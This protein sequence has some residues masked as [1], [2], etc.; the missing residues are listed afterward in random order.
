MVGRIGP[1]KSVGKGGQTGE[2]RT[3]SVCIWG[4]EAFLASLQAG[5][6][7]LTIG[8][9]LRASRPPFY[10]QGK[11]MRNG[12]EKRE[13]ERAG[14]MGSNRCFRERDSE[15]LR[16]PILAQMMMRLACSTEIAC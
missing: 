4:M 14:A 6:Q 13:N 16:S 7:G 8:A 12:T 11:G 10:G 1:R 15:F 9:G 5:K 2:I 3:A